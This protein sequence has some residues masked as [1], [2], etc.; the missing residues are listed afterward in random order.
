[1]IALLSLSLVFLV[2][3]VPG[4][5]PHA[6]AQS[7]RRRRHWSAPSLQSR[8]PRVAQEHGAWSHNIFAS[9]KKGVGSSKL[10]LVDIQ[11][12]SVVEPVDLWA[13]ML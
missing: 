4:S 3:S 11:P 6:T 13:A 12:S 5:A 9:F 7:R 2:L 10:H 1:M 8:S